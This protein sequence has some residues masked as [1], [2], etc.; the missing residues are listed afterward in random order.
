MLLDIRRPRVHLGER[1]GELA[2][3]RDRKPPLP[4]QVE[5]RK[6]LLDRKLF[7]LLDGDRVREKS[8]RTSRADRGVELTQRAR[9]GV[10]RIREHGLAGAHALLVH[11]LESAVG[12]V[13]LAPHFH[14]ERMPGTAQAKRY[15]LDRPEI[16]RHVLTDHAVA[17]RCAGDEHAFAIA[18]AHRGAVDLELACVAGFPNV[19]TH[20]FD[21]TFFPRL[22]L[23]SIER[24]GEGQ[25]R[26]E[27]LMFRKHRLRL[28]A[29]ATRR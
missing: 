10:T 23:S 15:L 20:Q 26:H 22:E 18:Q 25:H 28:D 1:R 12:H 27:V 16:R 5:Q 21:E 9:R 6:L 19:R 7:G 17:A 29:H 4:Q 13:H 11:L 2:V 14:H 24:V 3:W 8:K